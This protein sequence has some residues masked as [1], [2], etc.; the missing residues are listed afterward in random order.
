VF[1]SEVV[2]KSSNKVNYTKNEVT[3]TLICFGIIQ[4]NIPKDTCFRIKNIG[5][6]P[7]IIQNVETS[8]GCTVP[9]WTKKP[10]GIGEQGQIKI[11][12]DA[13]YPGHFY[14][15]ITVYSNIP[16]GTVQLYIEGEVEYD[17]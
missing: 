7:L 3:D 2:H 11:T 15:T 16:E 6:K 14:K 12:Y 8:C 10:I 1:S 13:K 5:D 4:H 17:K 9:V